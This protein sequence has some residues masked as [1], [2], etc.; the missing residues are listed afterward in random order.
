MTHTDIR[1]LLQWHFV[2]SKDWVLLFLG[3]LTNGKVHRWEHPHGRLKRY[4]T[5]LRADQQSRV[6]NKPNNREC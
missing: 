4:Q 1:E 2:S 5:T 3:A 6:H